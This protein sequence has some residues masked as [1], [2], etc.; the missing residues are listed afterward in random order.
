MNEKQSR[1][2]IA[3]C[4]LKEKYVDIPFVMESSCL[5][6]LCAAGDFFLRGGGGISSSSLALHSAALALLSIAIALPNSL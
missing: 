1:H 6:F 3:R 2:K 5:R 4:L